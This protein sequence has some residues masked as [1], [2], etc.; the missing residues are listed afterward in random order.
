MTY[1]SIRGWLFKSQL[2]Y[3]P[4]LTQNSKLVFYNSL[5]IGL[6]IF[7]QKSCLDQWKFSFL[8]F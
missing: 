7:L 3:N 2:A 1:V 5:F 6:E 4:R 8:K